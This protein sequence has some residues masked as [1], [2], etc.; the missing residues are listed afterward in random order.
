MST[1]SASVRHVCGVHRPPSAISRSCAGIC[2]AKPERIFPFQLSFRKAIYPI[3][4]VDAEAG[5]W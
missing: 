2:Q 4:C 3:C 5:C 1:R